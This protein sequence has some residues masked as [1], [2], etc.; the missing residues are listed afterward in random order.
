M[1]KAVFKAPVEPVELDYTPTAKQALFHASESKEVLYGGA[2][3][4]G[5]S[6]AIAMDALFR[7]LKHAG[8]MA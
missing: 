2:A 7:C 4:G 3:G 6:V 8:T 5:K 1:P